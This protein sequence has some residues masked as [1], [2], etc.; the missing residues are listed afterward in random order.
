MIKLHYDPDHQNLRRREIQEMERSTAILFEQQRPHP[1]SRKM[2]APKDRRLNTL[3]QE[4]ARNAT[5]QN[6][7]DD[8]INSHASREPF[9]ATHPTPCQGQPEIKT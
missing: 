7:N 8:G 2:E 3:I 5:N 4:N 1:S 6:T 9:H